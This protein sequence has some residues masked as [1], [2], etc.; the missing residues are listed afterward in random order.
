MRSYF[1][2]HTDD[3]RVRDEDLKKLWEGDRI[4]VHY[5][6]EASGLG[7]EDS[8]SIDPKRY[9]GSGRTAMRY[10][11][12]LCEN[13]GY[14]WAESFVAEDGAAKAGRV[15]AGSVVEVAQAVWD[16]RGRPYD[17]RR[18]GQRALLK[19][20]R[21]RDVTPIRRGES[22]GLRAGR[23]RGGTIV[24]W[25]KCGT[26][27]EDLVKGRPPREEWSNLSTEEQ[28]AVCA[29]F[30]RYPPKD[31]KSPS[32]RYLLVPV[33]R[34]LQDVDIHGLDATGEEIFAQVTYALVG[35]KEVEEKANKLR[36]YGQRSSETQLVLFCQCDLRCETDR[37]LFVPVEEVMIWMEAHPRYRSM[38]FPPTIV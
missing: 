11:N 2:R 6:D 37:I 36:R 35:T 26:R 29:E 30:L 23:P 22:N 33:G 38:L 18:D 8:G 28:E 3:L 32:L 20:L 19:T 5:P 16:L 1:V 15:E 27:L 7:D 12:E 34:T 25:R 13:G 4:A 9:A 10:L 14:V 21:L 31:W 24:R 17:G